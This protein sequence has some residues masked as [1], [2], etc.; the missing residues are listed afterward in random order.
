M[1][2]EKPYNE[3][4]DGARVPRLSPQRWEELRTF[5]LR[6]GD[7]F[8]VTYPKSGTTWTQQV[9]RLLRSGG[10]EDGQ[11]LDRAVPWLELQGSRQADRMKYD[12]DIDALRSPRAFKSHFLY[13]MVPGGL[14]HTTCARY[15]YVARN[16]KDVCV[17]LW[18]H[19]KRQGSKANLNK[20]ISRFLQGKV[21]YGSW[22][23]HVLEWWKHRNETNVLFLKYEDMKKKPH[24]SVRAI[25]EFIGMEDVTQELVEEVVAKSSF[26]SMNQNPTTNYRWLDGLVFSHEG[27]FMRKGIVGDWKNHFTVEQNA[28]FDRVYSHRMEGS[29]LKFEFDSTSEPRMKSLL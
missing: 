16:P 22:F 1:A 14:P 13:K 28:E 3:V 24:Q 9:V 26:S 21:L 18:Y 5:P 15:I 4:V 17:S 10:K 25:A 2:D 11:L 12:I 8:I 7:V 23:D 20:Y 6:L 29:Q 27:A 19:Y